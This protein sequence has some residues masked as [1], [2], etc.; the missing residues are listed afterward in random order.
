MEQGC[1]REVAK[2]VAVQ[3]GKEWTTKRKDLADS[4]IE[5]REVI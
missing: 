4:E 3:A 5:V 1:Y 2:V